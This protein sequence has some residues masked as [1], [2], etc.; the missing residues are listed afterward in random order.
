MGVLGAAWLAGCGG[1]GGSGA[2]TAT[3]SG[4][5]ASPPAARA[6]ASGGPFYVEAV[7]EDGTSQDVATQVTD[8]F[9]LDVPVNHDYVLVVGDGGGPI[10]GMRYGAAGSERSKFRVQG[11]VDLG[12][13]EVDLDR[14]EIRCLDDSEIEEPDDVDG[15]DNDADG[16]PDYA[17]D[18]DDN[19]G[20]DDDRDHVGDQ[21]TSR[22]HDND[23]IDDSADHDS[24]A[25]AG[26]AAYAALGCA[27]CHG[28]DGSGTPGYPES[29]RG[30]FAGEVAEVMLNGEGGGASDDDDGDDGD[31][32]DDGDD[33]GADAD[34]YMPSYAA[35][36]VAANAADIAAFLHHDGP[37]V[38]G[39]G[40]GDADGDGVADDLDQC[41]GTPAGVAV[42]ANGCKVASTPA[43]DGAALFVST[44]GGC[45]NGNGLGSGTVRDLTGK[46]AAVLQS[47]LAGGHQGFSAA[48]FTAAELD[49]ISAALTP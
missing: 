28:E 41:P 13:I 33:R 32:S 20:I 40:V 35:D 46:S 44:C 34:E 1:S 24:D 18:D 45:H 17:D 15:P 10:G 5:L 29:I 8:A 14:R 31:D 12:E 42:D 47:K 39:P 36:V 23:G 16:I 37:V 2:D 9:R 49:A 25:V 30:E 6:A 27:V 21:D 22:D 11:D 4:R 48:T 19:D 38:G 43:P 26:A 3:I 7:D